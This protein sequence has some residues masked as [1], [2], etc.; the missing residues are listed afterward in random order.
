MFSN[1]T[2]AESTMPTRFPEASEQ[3]SNGAINGNS[4]YSENNEIVISGISGRLPE[5]NSI[6]ELEENLFAGID[7]VTDDERRWPAGK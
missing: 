2:V 4:T 5:S 7:L 3:A 6:A 1:I